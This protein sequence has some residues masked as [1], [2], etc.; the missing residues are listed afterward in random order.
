MK[1]ELNSIYNLCS[2]FWLVPTY[3]YELNQI[4]PSK[5]KPVI[6]IIFTNI[7]FVYVVYGSLDYM[8][9][10]SI[11]HGYYFSTAIYLFGIIYSIW[12]I[13]IKKHQQLNTILH[14]LHN[15]NLILQ[16]H[17]SKELNINNLWIYLTHILFFI[18]CC[19]NLWVW[20]AEMHMFE[21]YM[22]TFNYIVYVNICLILLESMFLFTIKNRISHLNEIIGKCQFNEQTVDEIISVHQ[23]LCDSVNCFNNLFGWH[24]FF[25]YMQ[26]TINA[27]ICIWIFIGVNAM[28]GHKF[29]GF[30]L[31]LWTLYYLVSYLILFHVKNVKTAKEFK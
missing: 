15:C 31:A 22:V 4:T 6:K 18:V 16:K 21:F 13:N 28:G 23:C 20:Y 17:L 1:T 3:N 29:G 14:N 10:N 5:W 2:F 26:I 7:I 27:L 30:V 19:L 25:I 11:G 9:K 24:M 8:I 12:S